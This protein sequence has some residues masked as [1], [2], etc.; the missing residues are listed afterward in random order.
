MRQAE[1]VHDLVHGGG[2]VVTAE[3]PL[4]LGGG[5]RIDPDL[6]PRDAVAGGAELRIPTRLAPFVV[7]QAGVG[8]EQ[9]APVDI[10]R[11]AV[12]RPLDEGDG[13]DV[14]NDVE[15][16]AHEGAHLGRERLERQVRIRRGGRAF[17]EGI[18]DVDAGPGDPGTAEVGGDVVQGPYRLRRRRGRQV[19]RVVG[20][21]EGLVRLKIR[22]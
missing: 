16:G 22:P 13:N 14:G 11:R 2:E 5:V 8:A 19:R 12:V 1:A 17:T 9:D 3:E 18:G 21:H 15:G 4:A 6:R 10:G 7:R 20:G